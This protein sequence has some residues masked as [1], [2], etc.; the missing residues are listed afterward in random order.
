MLFKCGGVE[1]L[2][3]NFVDFVGYSRLILLVLFDVVYLTHTHKSL[4]FVF[5]VSM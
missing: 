3:F 5:Y 2:F 1:R 4:Y